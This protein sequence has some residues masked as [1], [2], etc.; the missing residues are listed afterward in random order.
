[1]WEPKRWR[2][3]KRVVRKVCR[4]VVHWA[5]VRDCHSGRQMA[6]RTVETMENLMKVELNNID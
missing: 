6:Y 3:R 2:G 1:M 4:R 5:G